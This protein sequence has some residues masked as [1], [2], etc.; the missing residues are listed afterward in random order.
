MENINY[1]S[2]EVS[3]NEVARLVLMAVEVSH[4][5]K[6]RSLG[7]DA[8]RKLDFMLRKSLERLLPVVR[9]EMVYWSRIYES[10]TTVSEGE[11]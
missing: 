10:E 3:R 2:V 5:M 6:G 7:S 4:K 11:R 8:K 1:K 9:E